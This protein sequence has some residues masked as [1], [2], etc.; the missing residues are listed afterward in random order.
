MDPVQVIFTSHSILSIMAPKV[1]VTIS[2]DGV[3]GYGD[4]VTGAPTALY[5]EAIK[6]DPLLWECLDGAVPDFD[7]ST[8]VVGVTTSDS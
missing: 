5:E 4:T 3:L 2:F 1:N 7:T 8:I 6:S